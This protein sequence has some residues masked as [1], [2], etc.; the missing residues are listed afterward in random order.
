MVFV[1]SLLKSHFIPLAMKTKKTL[2]A[3]LEN[4]RIIFF[5]IGILITL[6]AVLVAFEWSGKGNEN[7]LIFMQ[8]SE[9]PDEELTPITDQRKDNLVSPPPPVIIPVIISNTDDRLDPLELP[10]IETT[11]GEIIEPMPYRNE[12]P[13][14]DSNYV[15]IKS[16]EMPKYHGR[17]AKEF[18]KFIAQHL[19]YPE[20]AAENGV[21]GIV[22][23]RFIINERGDLVNAEIERSVDPALDQEALRVVSLSDRWTPGKQRSIPVKVAFVFPIEFSLENR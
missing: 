22:K 10:P 2:A 11:Q 4:K 16:E 15:F 20:I 8:T 19:R 18:G 6:S 13:E 14:V 1:V 3:N 17:P 9:I 21:Q 7:N 23:V 12:K 5:E